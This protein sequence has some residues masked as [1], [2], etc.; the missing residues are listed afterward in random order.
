MATRDEGGSKALVNE[1][2]AKM[3]GG[4]HKQSQI[5]T[6]TRGKR[7]TDVDFQISVTNNQ[8]RGSKG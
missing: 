7:G 8:L 6:I 5:P 1:K 4:S 3:K 2:E